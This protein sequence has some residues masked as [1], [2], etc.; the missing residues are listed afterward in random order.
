MAT[1][2]PVF[3][4]AGTVGTSTTFALDVAGMLS[5]DLAI[6]AI[7]TANQTTSTP[8]GW[9]AITPQGTGTAGGAAATALYLFYKFVTFAETVGRT[10]HSST[11]TV[12][13]RVGR[14]Y[15]FRYVDLVTPN[16]ATAVGDVE[17]SSTTSV[18]FPGITTANADA[19]VVSFIG[20][21]FDSATAQITSATN[22]GLTAFAYLGGAANAAGNG[23]GVY[24]FGGIKTAAGATGTGS[25]TLANAFQQA[26]ITLALRAGTVGNARVSQ[27]VLEV[28][29]TNN[30]T[31]ARV[32]QA[33]L[34]VARVKLDTQLRVSQAVLEVLRPNVAALSTARPVVFV[35]T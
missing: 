3:V 4:G 32:S 9:T 11:G 27:A 6:L 15:V 35:C 24:A 13:H 18:T 31:S 5:G 7:E 2:A 10:T 17:A 34:E 16:D 19:Y 33:V 28:A 23:G 8:S 25:G 12:D 30:A 14:V 29:R 21:G 22:A 26:R 1:T 20:S